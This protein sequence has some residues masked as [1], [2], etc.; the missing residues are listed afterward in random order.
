MKT[1]NLIEPLGD[2]KMFMT[3][4]VEKNEADIS[5]FAKE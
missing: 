1:R 5:N 4:T 2:K 3:L